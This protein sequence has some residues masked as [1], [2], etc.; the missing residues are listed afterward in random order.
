M[1]ILRLETY[2]ALLTEKQAVTLKSVYFDGLSFAKT[3]EK[4]NVTTE[5]AKSYRKAG[6]K[7]LVNMLN[8]ILR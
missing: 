7:S 8:D 4:L 5:T 3:A 1:N 6:I 2:V